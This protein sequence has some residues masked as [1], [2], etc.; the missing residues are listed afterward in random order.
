M[1]KG[2]SIY[3]LMVVAAPIAVYSFAAEITKFTPVLS[4]YVDGKGT[5]LKQPEGVACDDKSLLIA[6]DTGNGRLLRFTYAEGNL[7]P[8]AEIAVS[9][10][11]YPIKVQ[12]TSKGE[13]L[14]LDGKLRRIVRL[15]PGGEFKGYVEPE[16]ITSTGPI[17]PRSFK[18]DRN[19]N[20]Y[21]L[22]VYSLRILVLDP[23][24]K[25]QREIPLSQK[26]GFLSDL[27]VDMPGNIFLLDSVG[28]RIFTIAKESQTVSPLGDSLKEDVNFP[29]S[30]SVDPKGILY[31]V[32]ENGSGIVIIGQDG[33]FR[34]RRLGMGWK[35]GL[36]RYPSDM[37]M[38]KSGAVFI[39]DRGNSRIQIFSISQ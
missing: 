27:A 38:N 13:I 22:D 18:I 21:I 9:Q 15:T 14:A 20:I 35:E 3:L 1:R 11:P 30:I 25:V 10:L 7:S 28:K 32:D 24:G 17:V 23:T 31:V 8:G 6:A 29:T 37:C 39:A 33:S 4:I 19:D 2:F 5:G 16:G 12:V 34:G 26:F 36:L